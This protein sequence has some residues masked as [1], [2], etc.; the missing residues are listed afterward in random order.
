[1]QNIKGKEE[2]EE[3]KIQRKKNRLPLILLDRQF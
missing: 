2:E 1:M 3:N